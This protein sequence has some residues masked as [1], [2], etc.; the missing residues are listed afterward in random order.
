VTV[1]VMVDANRCQQRLLRENLLVLPY[2]FRFLNAYVSLKMSPWAPQPAGL[3]EIL[4]TIHESTATSVTVQRSIT[5]VRRLIPLPRIDC[6]TS[7]L[8]ET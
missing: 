1:T 4:Q 6:L 7:Y 8:L 3:Q 5:E 2:S